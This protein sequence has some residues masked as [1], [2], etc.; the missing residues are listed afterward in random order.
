MNTLPFT[1]V[2]DTEMLDTLRNNYPN[3]IPP[4]METHNDQL[5]HIDPD[6]NIYSSNIEKQCQ[7]YDTSEEFKSKYGILNNISLFHSNICSSAKKLNDLTYYLDGLNTS[8][9]FIGL[10]E[11]WANHTNKDILNI[12]GYKHEHCIRTN[13][14]GGGVSIYIL[15]TIQ[16]TIRKKLSLSKNM[17]ESLFIEIDKSVLKTKRNVIIGEIYRPPS[18]QLKHF[19]KE[20]ENL[21][22]AIEKEKKYAFLMGDYNVNTLE[23][24]Y[25]RKSLIQDFTNIFSL[26]YYHKLINLSTRERK[27]SSTL[28]DNIY[29]NIPDCY[30]TCTSGVMRFLTQSDH[31]PI[32]TIRNDVEP[33]KSN[34]HISKRNHSHKNIAH[35]KRRMNKLNFNT[36][37]NINGITPAFTL[38]MNMILETFYECFP[39]ESIKISYKNR[40]PWINQ[41][42][43]NEIKVRD[44]LFLLYKNKPTQT[45]RDN[46]KK[47]KNLNLSNQRKAE[48]DYYRDK[49]ELHQTDL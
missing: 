47:I 30:N 18:S 27:G 9:S 48:R 35:F 32:F 31:Y 39:V 25:E 19:N 6:L 10:C 8:F 11:T 22:N 44:N 16:Y 49:F 36:I 37:F 23:E 26:H 29:T 28:L 14:K 40:N 38:F 15:N 12:P 33:P 45:N 20:L 43:K 2:R 3:T 1:N 7:N 42:L 17:F 24:I 41:K 13:N 21:L 46:Y 4:Y 5:A 34:T